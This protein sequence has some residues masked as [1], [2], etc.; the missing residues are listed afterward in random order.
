MNI[1]SLGQGIDNQGLRPLMGEV[2][3]GALSSKLFMCF[4]YFGPGYLL[5]V[6]GQAL[7]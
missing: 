4:L 5:L 7:E 6:I 3:E 1:K 2:H